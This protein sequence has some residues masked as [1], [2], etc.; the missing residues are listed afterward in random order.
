MSDKLPDEVLIQRLADAAALVTVGATYMHYKHQPYK[1][2]NLAI[3]DDGNE[4]CV[5]YQML[6][7]SGLTF[8]RTISNWTE[9]VEVNGQTVPRFAKA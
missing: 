2:L 6:Y 5:V 8:I 7:G 1:V 3:A 4:I 9:T